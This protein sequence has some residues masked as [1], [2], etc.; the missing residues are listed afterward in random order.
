MLDKERI[1]RECDNRRTIGLVTKD[2]LTLKTRLRHVDIYN[3][4]LRQEYSRGGI[5]I[6][7]TESSRIMADGLTKTLPREVQERNGLGQHP[8]TFDQGR[9]RE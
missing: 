9:P 2:N 1:R 7:N 4:W 6:K 8:R 5:E 3:R